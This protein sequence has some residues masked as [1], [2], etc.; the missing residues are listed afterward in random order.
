MPSHQNPAPGSKS[1][2]FINANPLGPMVDPFSQIAG[3]SG[4]DN[5]VGLSYLSE[6]VNDRLERA[7]DELV[8]KHKTGKNER[9]DPDRAPTGTAYQPSIQQQQQQQQEQQYAMQQQQQQQQ[10]SQQ[11]PQQQ[12]TMMIRPKIKK[13]YHNDSDEDDSDSDSEYDHLLDE[14]E[15]GPTNGTGG[16]GNDDINNDP[17]IQAMKQRRINELK[18]KQIEYA[19]NIAKGHGQLRT[20]SQDEFLPECTGSSQYVVIHFFH[21]EFKRCTIMDHHLHMVARQHMET[22]FC[23]IDA[24]KSPFFIQKLNIQ[25]LPTLLIFE[26]GKTVN[27]L[28][29]FNGLSEGNNNI[30]TWKTY[31][32]QI[33]LAQPENGA[34][35]T[36]S[37]PR[38][39]IGIEDD[40][41]MDHIGRTSSNNHDGVSKFSSIYRSAMGTSSIDEF[42]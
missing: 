36:I 33:Y 19:K 16:D 4:N 42:H 35:I 5:D 6:N 22:K 41:E 23:R 10:E 40:D 24:E 30:D 21:K 38:Q 20:I 34:C 31:Q 27:R 12:P 17:I 28:I 9:D 8:L 15:N 26:N 14:F 39:L 13:N 1:A 32:L 3:Q 2:K 11:Q 7:M 18:N 25:T 37:S 29:G